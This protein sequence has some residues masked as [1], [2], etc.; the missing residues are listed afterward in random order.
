MKKIWVVLYIENCESETY[1][2]DVKV[3]TTKPSDDIYND[4]RGVDVREF[5]IE[6]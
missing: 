3:L 1:V 6:C 4:T 2:D 5:E